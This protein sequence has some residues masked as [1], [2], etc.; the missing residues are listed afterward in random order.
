L[1]KMLGLT[2]IGDLNKTHPFPL[3]LAAEKMGLAS[4]NHGSYIDN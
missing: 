1:P 4:F 2:M 3:S